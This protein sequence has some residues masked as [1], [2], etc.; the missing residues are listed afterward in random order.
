MKYGELA[1]AL[2]SIEKEYPF[3]QSLWYPN[4]EMTNNKIYHAINVLLFQWIPAYFIDL[5]LWI[6]RQPR[7]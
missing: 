5:L 1:D 4:C 2:K 3:S 6:F 7:L